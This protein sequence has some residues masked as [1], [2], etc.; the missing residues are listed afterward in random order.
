MSNLEYNNT[1][2]NLKKIIV[3]ICKHKLPE[4]TIEDITDKTRLAEDMDFDSVDFI[5]LIFRIEE[6]FDLSIPEE[7][8]DS[9][10]NS[11]GQLAGYIKNSKR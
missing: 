11:F 3:D 10:L 1:E 5:D 2:E 6:A 4:L 7:N 8:F 9:V